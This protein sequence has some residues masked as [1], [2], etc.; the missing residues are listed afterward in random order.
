MVSMKVVTGTTAR[1]RSALLP[2]A[3]ALKGGLYVL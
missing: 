1:N 3:L 2:P